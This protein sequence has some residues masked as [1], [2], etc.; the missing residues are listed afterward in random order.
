MVREMARK[1]RIAM[2][3]CFRLRVFAVSMIF[4]IA[5]ASAE[6]APTS[7]K[8]CRNDLNVY[9]KLGPLTNPSFAQIKAQKN[10][11]RSFRLS[12]L[13]ERFKEMG[14][15]METD[16]Q[17]EIGYAHISLSIQ[18]EETSRYVNFLLR[19]G[20]WDQFVAEDAQGKR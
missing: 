7:L 1:R 5:F 18:Q 11:L 4:L 9:T 20:S 14:D 2:E 17:N 19:H 13:S 6:E 15:C 8:Q 12:E 16:P 3:G 10:H